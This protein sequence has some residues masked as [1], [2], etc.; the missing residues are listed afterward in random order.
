MKS[1]KKIDK[2][3]EKYSDPFIC[4]NLPFVCNKTASILPLVG[5]KL[6][7]I[8]NK[9]FTLT[10]ILITLTIAGIL[11]AVSV[12]A[13]ST[14]VKNHRLSSQANDLLADLTFARTEAVKRAVTITVCKQDSSSTS[15]R[16]D[17]TNTTP[18]SAGW[19]VFIDSNNNGQIDTSA[20]AEQVL[21]IRGSVE[22]GNY[23]TA[24][25]TNAVAGS[26]YDNAANLIRFRNTGVTTIDPSTLSGLSITGVQVNGM[27]RIRLCD[28]RGNRNAL[29]V[30]ITSL[31]RLRVNST[32]P[33]LPATCPILSNWT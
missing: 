7:I 33:T 17:Q 29:T 27:A 15:P 10:E 1:Y 11:A 30:E 23:V 18:W 25:Q 8:G 32:P 3:S 6:P 28:D 14:F 4:Q 13:M 24:A 22:G 26:G 19:V 5:I 20:P 9:G 21:R 12:P 2:K 31:G 16:C